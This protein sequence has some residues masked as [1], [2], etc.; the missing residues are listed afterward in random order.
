VKELCVVGLPDGSGEKVA[1]IVVPST[2]R[3][4][5]DEVRA[6]S[7]RTCARS[8]RRSVREAREGVA[9]PRRRAAEDRDAQGEAR[10][11]A[12]ELLARSRRAEGRRAREA[13]VEHGAGDGWL[14]DLLAE[15]SAG[16]APR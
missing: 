2:A 13:A 3:D 1:L 5:R 7:R 4:D 16:R 6:R 12:R 8:P 10:P 9:R 14:L 11:R 15:V